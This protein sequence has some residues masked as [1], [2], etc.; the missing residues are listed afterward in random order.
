MP[1]TAPRQPIHVEL[2]RDEALVLFELLARFEETSVLKL[3]RNAEF[4][5]ISALAGQLQSILEEPFDRDYKDI[6][7][8]S[9]AR[10][11]VGYEGLAPGVEP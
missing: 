1:E 4:I 3:M 7:A 11:E 8:L 9:A 5:A 6:V 2:S 10:L